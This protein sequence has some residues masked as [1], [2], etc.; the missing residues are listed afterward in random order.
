MDYDCIVQKCVWDNIFKECDLEKGVL[1]SYKEEGHKGHMKSFYGFRNYTRKT[2][3]HFKS[4]QVYP[5]STGIFMFKPCAYMKRSFEKLEAFILRNTDIP[6]FYEQSGMNVYFNTRNMAN[7]TLL[8]CIVH[9]KNIKPNLAGKPKIT[10]T[11]VDPGVVITHF[12]GI[13]Y[14][15]EKL[16]RMSRY[17]AM[18][19]SG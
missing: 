19:E 16:G 9:S 4:E 8:K 13:G 14:H 18:V 11:R 2:L 3:S 7:T 1:Y 5:F 12:C 10:D 17:W 6:H 15:P